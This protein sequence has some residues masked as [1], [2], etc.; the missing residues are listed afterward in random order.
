MLK[1]HGIQENDGGL[2]DGIVD[3]FI[4]VIWSTEKVGAYESRCDLPAQT[5]LLAPHTNCLNSK[6]NAS[7]SRANGAV[8]RPSH[9]A[10]HSSVPLRVNFSCESA[11]LFPEFAKA[12]SYMGNVTTSLMEFR[13]PKLLVRY[14]QGIV[15]E[16]R[17]R[18]PGDGK[19][20]L[21]GEIAVFQRCP[22]FHVTKTNVFPIARLP[23]PYTIDSQTMTTLRLN[24]L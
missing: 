5:H 1:I 8:I 14:E 13:K 20:D 10:H 18:L 16:V 22:V 24:E 7:A 21:Y 17:H 6:A 4:L 15:L 3:A 23:S 2:L 9:K 11:R 12:V 19:Q